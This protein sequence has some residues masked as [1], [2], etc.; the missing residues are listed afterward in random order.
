MKRPKAYI[1]P[2][3]RC[4][5]L[6]TAQLERF[7]LGAVPHVQPLT[8]EPT[9]QLERLG[10]QPKVLRPALGAL[11]VLAVLLWSAPVLAMDQSLD[12]SQYAHT[13]WTFRS[14]FLNGAVYAIAQT[15]EGYLWL[16]TQSGVVRFDGVRAVPLSLPPGQELPSTA[17][18]ALLAASDGT[19]WI[20]PTRFRPALQ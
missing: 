14:G 15:R 7:F 12:V 17:V 11:G 18:G 2:S 5:M 1:K 9:A 19:L 13:A 4:R 6:G 8:V 3:G 10:C 20:R 16:G